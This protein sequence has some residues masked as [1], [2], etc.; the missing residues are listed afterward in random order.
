MTQ[1]AD[2][3][4]QA[5]REDRRSILCALNM[6][7][8]NYVPGPSLFRI[9]VGTSTEYTKQRMIRDM[10]YFNDKGYVKFKGLHGIEAM[11]IA[12]SD[13]AYALT[14]D[15]LDVAQRLVHDPALDV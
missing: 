2:A 14:P 15:G 4:A 7:Y 12:V 1:A 10:T 13:C 8:P 3:T 6:R 9:I 5:I 11:R